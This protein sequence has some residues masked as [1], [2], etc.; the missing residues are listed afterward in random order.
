MSCHFESILA[1][2]TCTAELKEKTGEA[3]IKLKDLASVAFAI[4]LKLK[5]QGLLL[6]IA[7][8]TPCRRKL[9]LAAEKERLAKEFELVVNDYDDAVIICSQIFEEFDAVLGIAPRFVQVLLY[10]VC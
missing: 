4:K 8:F 3:L 5:R 10:F 7:L 2:K 1:N 9:L 6:H